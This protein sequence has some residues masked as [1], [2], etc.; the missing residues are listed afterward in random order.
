MIDQNYAVNVKTAASA[1]HVGNDNNHSD[2]DGGMLKYGISTEYLTE[3]T[4]KENWETIRMKL[5]RNRGTVVTA[6]AGESN[7][8]CSI[9]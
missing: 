1:E 4:E 3:L 2:I 9:I 6:T 7:D 8:R 5:D